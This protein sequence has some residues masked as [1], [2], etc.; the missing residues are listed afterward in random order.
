MVSV[1]SIGNSLQATIPED[2]GNFAEPQMMALNPVVSF[3]LS[4]LGVVPP[5]H[6]DIQ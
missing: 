3:D 5:F 6:L 4:T 1:Q 2:C